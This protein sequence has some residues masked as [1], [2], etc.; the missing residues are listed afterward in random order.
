MKWLTEDADLRCTHIKGK[1]KLDVTQSWVRVAGRRVLIEPNT[2]RRSISGCPMYGPT[3][4][5]CTL[6]LAVKKGY[7]AWITIDGKPVCLDTIT[8]LT[9]GT[10]PGTVEYKALAPGQNLVEEK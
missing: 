3:I 10:P 1:V 2:E 7:S 4:K 9:D 5:P 8:G 6:T